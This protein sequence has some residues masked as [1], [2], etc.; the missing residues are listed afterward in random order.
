MLGGRATAEGTRRLASRFAGILDPDHFRAGADGLSL[1]SVG[2]G[3]YL[4]ADDDGTDAAYV[5]TVAEGLLRGVNVLDVAINY[6]HQRSERAFGRALERTI[7][8][9]HAARDEV[10]VATKCGFVAFDGAVPADPRGWFARTHLVPGLLTREDI[11]ADCHS[12][13]PRFVDFQVER[14]R[15]N[16]G[17]E[18]IDVMYLHNPEIQ[19]AEIGAERFRER[20]RLAF[21]TLERHVEA[22]AIA[23]YGL[24]TWRGFLVERGA[25]D[26]LSLEDVLTAVREVAGERHHLS[27]LQLPFNA[28]MT[29]AL[30]AKNQGTATRRLSLLEHAADAGL[31]VMTSASVGQG[32]PM[33]CP[34]E[35]DTGLATCAQQA[36]QF[37]RSAPGVTTALCGT[38]DPEHLRENLAVAAIPPIEPSAYA[39][40]ADR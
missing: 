22:G 17:V 25:I 33:P 5:E 3:G 30:T 2:L 11:V 32:R 23:R 36:L 24:A 18:T 9:G 16:L 34:L 6:R 29:E 19:R 40:L 31:T 14:S 20:L 15:E 27:V 8:Q 28:A 1:S 10:V 12:I 4:G 26:H 21:E 7:E 39:A 38:C 13:A 35:L 37:A